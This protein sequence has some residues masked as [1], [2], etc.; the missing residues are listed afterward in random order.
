MIARYL[1]IGLRRFEIGSQ[2]RELPPVQGKILFFEPKYMI[3]KYFEI[4]L[5]RFEI[6][7]QTRESPP[8]I[9]KNTIFLFEIIKFETHRKNLRS[10]LKFWKRPPYKEKYNFLIF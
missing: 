4:G 3:L 7:S 1:K 6:G 10:G 5:R 8:R 9:R 2:I